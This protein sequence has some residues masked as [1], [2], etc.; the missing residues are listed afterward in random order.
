[1][2]IWGVVGALGRGAASEEW[3]SECNGLIT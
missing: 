1:M 2:W 3:D